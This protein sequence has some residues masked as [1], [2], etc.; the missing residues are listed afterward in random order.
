MDDADALA[1]VAK[2]RSA[3]T[4]A[5]QALADLDKGGS[6]EERNSFAAELARLQSTRKQDAADL[7]ATQ[8]LQ[9]KG[10]TSAAEVAAAQHRLESDDEAIRVNQRRATSRYGEGDHAR[11]QAQLADAQAALVAA[12]AAYTNAD[13]RSPIAGTVY[14]ISASQYDYLH[15]GDDIMD[16]ADL[17]NIQ[18]RA[19]FDE[20]DIGKLKPGQPVKIVWEAKPTMVWHGHVERAPTTI[21]NYGTRNVGE[22]IVSVDDSNGDLAPNSD[23][24]VTVTTAEHPHVLSIP[25]EA[26][27]TDGVKNFVYKVVDGKLVSTPVQVDV[28]NLTRVQIAAGLAQNDMVALSASGNRELEDGL[29]VAPIPVP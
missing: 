16:V 10:A 3:V 13:Q 23:V 5:Q 28:V 9:Q 29:P 15:A 12:Q 27:H 25:R 24:T 1:A 7:A 2:A 11:A 4:A 20:P 6:Q 26:L 18:V 17:K 21:V 22:G 14:S 8:Q 19:Y